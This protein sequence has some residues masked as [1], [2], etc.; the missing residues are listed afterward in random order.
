[1]AKTKHQKLAERYALLGRPLIK[2]TAFH[3][4]CFL[5]YIGLKSL[6]PNPNLRAACHQFPM[7]GILL[8]RSAYLFSECR[9]SSDEGLWFVPW[10]VHI[11]L[12]KENQEKLERSCAQTLLFCPLDDEISNEIDWFEQEMAAN[13]LTHQMLSIFEYERQRDIV[14]QNLLKDPYPIWQKAKETW[15]NTERLALDAPSIF[16][17]VAKNP[18]G[19][20][21]TD[22]APQEG[23]SLALAYEAILRVIRTRGY[24]HRQALLGI[25]K[26][27]L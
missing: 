13:S 2:E 7:L 9:Q 4:M 21:D 16:Y 11:V 27:A 22:F 18:Q 26:E 24:R 23:Q 6:A 20:D 8:N 1:M 12:P 25:Y 5:H 19:V 14:R 17:G 15:Q 3:N 10:G